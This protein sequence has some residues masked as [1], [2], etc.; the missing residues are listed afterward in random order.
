LIP[1][2]LGAAAGHNL[3]AWAVCAMRDDF[4]TM[5]NRPRR[6]KG[7]TAGL[8]ATAACSL[9]VGLLLL[10]AACSAERQAEPPDLPAPLVK[11]IP[12]KIGVHYTPGFR[13]AR[14][15][16]GRRPWKVG[17]ASVAL[18]EATLDNLFAEVVHVDPWPS[19][20]KAPALAAVIVPEVL[21]IDFGAGQVSIRYAVELFSTRG[22]RITGWKIEGQ[23]TTPPGPPISLWAAIGAEQANMRHAMRAAGAALVESFYSDPTARAWLE[24][25]GVAPDSLK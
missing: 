19:G 25:N 2:K 11:R 7:S 12:L 17:D 13:Q 4:M 24:A 6:A 3:F 21:G 9:A 18:F 8:R 15:T 22:E 5:A 16:S 10:G 23:W 1:V 14:Q 20:D